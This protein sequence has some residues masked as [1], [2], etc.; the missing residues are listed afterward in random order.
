MGQVLSRTIQCRVEEVLLGSLLDDQLASKRLSYLFDWRNNI[1]TRK[2]TLL[3]IL[4]AVEQLADR[5]VVSFADEVL[6][7]SDGQL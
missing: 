1:P 2:H 3:F 5:F 4:V 7:I 6:F